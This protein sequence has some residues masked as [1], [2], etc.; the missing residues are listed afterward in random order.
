MLSKVIRLA[1][2]PNFCQTSAIRSEIARRSKAVRWYTTENQPPKPQEAAAAT[3][4]PPPA[5]AV[6]PKP[7]AVPK[8]SSKEDPS[9][10]KGPITWKS[11]GFAAFAGAGLLVSTKTQILHQNDVILEFLRH[12]C[13]M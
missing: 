3:P 13:T 2:L 5:T 7:A 8:S 11:L 12:S 10:G 9:K 1:K 4:K 6:P